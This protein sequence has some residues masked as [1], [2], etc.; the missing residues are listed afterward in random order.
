MELTELLSTEAALPSIPRVVALLLSELSREQP[1]LRKI[2]QLISS[3]PT[4]ASRLLRLANGGA[5]PFSNAIGSIAEALAVLEMAELRP[6]ATAAAMA[7]TIRTVPGI[8]L[9][10]FWRYSLNTAK[11]CRSLAANVRQNQATA[12]TAGLVHAMGELVMHIAMPA[13]VGSLNL[14]AGPFDQRRAKMEQRMFGYTYADVSAGLA[15]QWH[16]PE[17]VVL[18]LLHQ[19]MPFEN[20]VYEP[21]AGV[22]H[23]ASWRARANEAG[24]DEKALVVSFPDQVALVLGLDIDIVL[25]QDPIDWSARSGLG[26]LI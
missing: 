6:L 13:D 15:R 8:H 14:M 2:S 10:Q 7:G 21:L 19:V 22:V 3:D 18:A 17:T 20:D 24:L 4:L 5:S 26:A 12:F 9:Q 1:D 11:L 23:L 16:F 25:Q